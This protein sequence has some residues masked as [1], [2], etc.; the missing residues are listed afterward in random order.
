MRQRL[1]EHELH[2]PRPHRSFGGKFKSIFRLIGPG[3]IT[4]A[5]DDDPSGIGTYAVAGASFGFATLWTALVTFPLMSAVQFMCAK[6]GMVTGEGLAGVLKRH[7]RSR[8]LY[9]AV[10][11]LVI[12]NTINA[13]ADIGAIA[14]SINL[15]LPVP[16]RLLIV[17]ISILIVVVQTWGSYRFIA[18]TFKWLTFS[19]L[20]YIGSAFFAHPNLRDVMHATF[21]PEL[22]LDSQF[23]SVLVAIFGTTISPYLFFWQANQEVEED[24]AHGKRTLAER[25]GA[26][27]AELHYAAWDVNIGMLFSNIVMYFIILATG[28]TLFASGKTT[29]GSAA[30]AAQALQPL[31][32]RFATTLFAI[33]LIG[34][35]VLAVPVLTGSSAYAVAEAFGWAHG[36]DK[37]PRRASRFYILIAVS[38]LVGMLINFTKVNAITALF[39]TAILNGFLAPPLLVLIMMI[40]N[41]RSIMGNRVN[42]RIVNILGWTATVVMFLAA[43]ALLWTW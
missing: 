28:A 32:G 31:V 1:T 36:L 38:T 15:L 11:L 33:G 9:P 6:I 18:K 4:G 12:A 5:S 2:H 19:L 34:A 30:A 24:I 22:K 29:V 40:S 26:S 13:G 20:A 41:N 10:L 39:W 37:K 16:P 21:V 43:I 25:K 14:A 8:V 35:G 3:F 17:P 7:Y 23:L 27:K 42:G